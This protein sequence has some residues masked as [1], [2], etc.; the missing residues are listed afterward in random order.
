MVGSGR[1]GR[2]RTIGVEERA[3]LAAR[4]YIRHRCTSYEDDL[5]DTAV[6]DDE[7][8]YREVKAAAQ[9]AVDD[10]LASHRSKRG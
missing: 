9:Q 1:V 10:F 7:F 5:A 6:W 8:L 3:A 2:T 4:A